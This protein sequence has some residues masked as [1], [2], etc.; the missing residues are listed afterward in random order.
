MGSADKSQRSAHK[1]RLLPAAAPAQHLKLQL[2]SSNEISDDVSIA[3][4]PAVRLIV[5]PV[6]SLPPSPSFDM[7]CAQ[8]SAVSPGASTPDAQPSSSGRHVETSRPAP[9]DED[10]AHSPQC[11]C[12]PLHDQWAWAASSPPAL[13]HQPDSMVSPCEHHTRDCEA[14]HPAVPAAQS[15]HAGQCP[16]VPAACWDACLEHSLNSPPAVTQPALA[17]TPVVEIACDVWDNQHPYISV[18]VT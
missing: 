12:P 17:S 18:F 15:S 9:S 13:R 3:A 7:V 14:R 1:S 16:R 2:W 4:R 8:G 5:G 11:R 6:P 10:S